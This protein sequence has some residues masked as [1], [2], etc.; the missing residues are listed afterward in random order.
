MP[1][2]QTYTGKKIDIERP[3]SKLI[4]IRD[5]AH[6]LSLQC[7]FAGQCRT[8]YSIAQHSIYAYQLCKDQ[9]FD[10]RMWALLHDA[11]EA[12]ISDVSTPVKKLL[13]S[14][15]YYEIKLLLK[16]SDRFG[17]SKEIPNY[18]KKVDKVLLMTEAR[19]LMG[20]NNGD[21]GSNMP[22]P[23]DSLKIEPLPW[24]VCE[25]RFLD[26]FEGEFQSG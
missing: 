26:I 8:F 25:A 21:W 18:V 7:R 2:I 15:D 4:D 6:G 16:I 11:A 1:W 17:L 12:Y 9:P 3:S 10:I 24:E 5:I 19:D 14:Y 20:V 22:K 13:E 23:L